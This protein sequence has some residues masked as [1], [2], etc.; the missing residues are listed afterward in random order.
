VSTRDILFVG[1]VPLDDARA[2]F[3]TLADKVGAAAP[4]LPDGE[5]G[6]RINWLRW[7]V[8]SFRDNPALV[9]VVAN[10]AL[11]DH[12]DTLVRPLFDLRPGVSDAQIAF[13]ELGYA[14]EAILSF[15]VFAELQQA[16]RIAPGTRFQVSVPTAIDLVTSYVAESARARVEPALEAAL[17]REVA[18]MAE[19]IPPQRLAVQWDA[20]HAPIVL[21]GGGSLHFSDT[22]G[23]SV[24]RIARHVGFVPDGV[25]AAVH[26]CYGDPGHKHVVEPGDLATC[27]AFANGICAAAP[28]QVDWIHMPVPRMRDDDAYFAPLAT[29][30]LQP[31]T[32]LYLGL[33]HHSDGIDGAARRIATAQRHVAAFGIATECGF[34][35]RDPATLPALLDIHNAALA[36]P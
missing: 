35:R 22:L 18:M 21:D 29:L 26:L 8:G 23:G 28:R 20:A 36:L 3:T 19:A 15:R 33:I 14:R 31:G 34:G 16:G 11:A 7:Q 30:Q 4:R 6:A 25:E 32:R 24:E 2:V 5:T 10:R 27:V 9:L 1:S 17:Q 12:N 13:G